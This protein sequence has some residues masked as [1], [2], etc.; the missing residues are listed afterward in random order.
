[1]LSVSDEDNINRSSGGDLIT[2]N[3]HSEVHGTDLSYNHED[4]SDQSQ[5]VSTS[6]GGEK[7]QRGKEFAKSLHLSTPQIHTG[8]K[9]YSCSECGKCFTE[10]SNLV[11]HERVHTGEKPYSCSECGKCFTK[12]SHLVT[13]KTIH[14][15]EKPYSCSKCGKCFKQSSELVT[16]E[17]SHIGDELYSC[18]DCGKGFT[19]KSSLVRHERIHT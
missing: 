4:S 17:N 3:V 18:S 11:L 15:G 2:L 8:E 1:M 6:T 12:I 16:H 7:F 10:K 9:P 14:T 5:I 19:D 13:H